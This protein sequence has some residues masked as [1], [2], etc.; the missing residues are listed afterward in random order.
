ML[1]IIVTY[2]CRQ[3]KRDEFLA[4]I[5]KAQIGEKCAA[6]PG[7]LGYAYHLPAAD[8]DD[9]VLIEKWADREALAPHAKTPHFAQLTEIKA[10]YVVSMDA[11]RYLAEPTD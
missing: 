7:C 4:A 11:V 9:V 5:S 1:L 3:G 2:H 8:P 10:Q 6:E